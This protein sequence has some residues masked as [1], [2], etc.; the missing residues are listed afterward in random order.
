MGAVLTLLALGCGMPQATVATDVRAYLERSRQ[1]ASRESEA[2]RTIER[3]LRTE[4]VDEAEVRRQ[5]ADNRP[6]S[7]AHLEQIRAYQPRSEPVMRLHERYVAAWQTLLAGFDAI[8]AGFKSGDYTQLA[9]GREA[10]MA[11]RGGILR[12]ASDL[13]RMVRRYGLQPAGAVES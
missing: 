4:F 7:Q 3:I 13:R 10:I 12:V 11:W 9:R 5:I 1:W 8:E 6:R 2:E